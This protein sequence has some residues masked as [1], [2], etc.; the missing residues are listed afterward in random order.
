MDKDPGYGGKLPLVF[1]FTAKLSPDE[2]W[3]WVDALRKA[4]RVG[5]AVTQ[6]RYEDEVVTVWLSGD[7]AY[8]LSLWLPDVLREYIKPSQMIYPRGL[9]RRGK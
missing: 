2:A 4:E 1:P 7:A 6:H 5:F 9:T 3:R 8:Y